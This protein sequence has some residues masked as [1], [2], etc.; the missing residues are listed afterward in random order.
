MDH[1]WTIILDGNSSLQWKNRKNID[2]L[3]LAV[4]CSEQLFWLWHALSKKVVLQGMPICYRTIPKVMC[5]AHSFKCI[6][7]YATTCVYNWALNIFWIYCCTTTFAFSLSSSWAAPLQCRPKSNPCPVLCGWLL[8]LGGYIG[9][10]SS[11]NHH[12]SHHSL[13]LMMSMQTTRCYN[14]H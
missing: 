13:N 11:Q 6:Y 1:Q 7:F 5:Y 2:I 14:H 12:C 9:S 3:T 4:H 8:L 10:S